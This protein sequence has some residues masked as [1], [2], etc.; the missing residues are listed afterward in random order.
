MDFQQPPVVGIDTLDDRAPG[1]TSATIQPVLRKSLI[2]ACLV[3]ACLNLGC[4]SGDSDTE[5]PK[6]KSSQKHESPEAVFGEMKDAMSNGDMARFVECMTPDAANQFV[7][8]AVLG[9][10]RRA[11]RVGKGDEDG[12]NAEAILAVLKKHGVTSEDIEQKLPNE[13]GIG[14]ER[15]RAVGALVKDKKAF[16]TELFKAF[17]E[18]VRNFPQDVE[19]IDVKID[20][21][22][23][24]ARMVLK[25]SGSK[26]YE[27]FWF[28]K[29][30][31]GW[32]IDAPSRDKQNPPKRVAQIEKKSSE[33]GDRNSPDHDDS[34]KI[35]IPTT[36]GSADGS[37]AGRSSSD[38]VDKVT[39][40]VSNEPPPDD[41][42]EP[43]EQIATQNGQQLFQRNCATCHSY[44][45]KRG[46]GIP[47]PATRTDRKPNGA[48]NLHG[49]ASREWLRGFLD[50]KQILNASYFGNTAHRD[51]EMVDVVV[52]EFNDLGTDEREL[53]DIII[54]AL[55]AEANLPAQREADARAKEDGSIEKGIS[56]F[57]EGISS[58][59]CSDCHR[60][61]GFEGDEG[62][63]DLTGYGSRAWLVQFISNPASDRFYG[64]NN[65]RMPTFSK[66]GKDG[67]P[68]P[69]T[70]KEIETI[71]D[72][73]RGMEMN[74]HEAATNQPA[75][76]RVE[77]E[78]DEQDPS[79]DE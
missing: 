60:F 71:V 59:A 46:F 62:A 73:M 61:R 11:E 32:L 36:V 51:G 37:S 10:T 21:D 23:A 48:S 20:G 40:K 53:L 15:D 49:F 5:S 33:A 47:G 79:V 30:D 13:V 25:R 4:G 24:T 42:P 76:S 43:S 26:Q 38:D 39:P 70:A 57:D 64:E 55:S 1:R 8:D 54:I 78:Q 63:P 31:G 12:S 75:A 17:N 68:E 72:W 9:A 44:V 7:G 27:P 22:R 19:L 69:L 50:S 66:H 16:I 58:V 3:F 35:R 29:I 45:D 18:D 14:E 67:G 28:R 74:D 77:P 65:D 52:S 6:D 34:A 41:V 56:V 2:A